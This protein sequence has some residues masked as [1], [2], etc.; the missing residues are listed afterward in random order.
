[1]KRCIL[2]L[3][4]T[5]VTSATSGG[6]PSTGSA[7]PPSPSGAA[8]MPTC[9]QLRRPHGEAG[10][11]SVVVYEVATMVATSHPAEPPASS[12]ALESVR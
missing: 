8:A 1:M 10:R 4:R 2:G 11:R 7:D 6:R 12:R 5:A 9:P 3:Y